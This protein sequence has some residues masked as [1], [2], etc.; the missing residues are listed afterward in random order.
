M[1]VSSN[2]TSLVIYWGA[3]SSSIGSAL[4]DAEVRRRFRAY[5]E[6]YVLR[7]R[8]DR[9]SAPS[10]V[11]VASVFRP[12]TSGHRPPSTPPLATTRAHRRAVAALLRS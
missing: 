2:D 8:P 6:A 10:R 7:R 5:L 12:M 4:S 11:V 1:V 9:Q 3:S